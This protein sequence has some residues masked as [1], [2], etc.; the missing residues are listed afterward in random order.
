MLAIAAASVV[1]V[2][3]SAWINEEKGKARGE[4]AEG[5]DKLKTE[6]Q[7]TEGKR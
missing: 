1:V 3:I 5:R 4:G 6:K 2:P 7:K